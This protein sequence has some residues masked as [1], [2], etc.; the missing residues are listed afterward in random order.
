[1]NTADVVAVTQGRSRSW[2]RPRLAVALG[3]TSRLVSQASAKA[4]AATRA[5]E[6]AEVVAKYARGWLLF[7]MPGSG[8]PDFEWRWL[9]KRAI[10]TPETAKVP[11]GLRYLQRRRGLEIRLG[12][13]FDAIIE[14]CQ[15][16]RSG[17]LTDPVVEL[18][19][20]SSPRTCRPR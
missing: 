13:D 12:H 8:L 3:L 7:G 10:V 17:W 1:M 15:D 19:T 2:L 20:C 9:P 11:K 18:G 6:P 5:P 16:G 14:R 4:G